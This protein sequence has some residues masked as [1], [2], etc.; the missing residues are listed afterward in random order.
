LTNSLGHR[1]GILTELYLMN[2]GT[3]MLGVL[4]GCIYLLNLG[5]ICVMNHS[6]QVINTD[7][8]K[9]DTLEREV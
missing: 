3:H 5:F 4:T 1:A 6:Q 2:A 7:K 9:S 8:N